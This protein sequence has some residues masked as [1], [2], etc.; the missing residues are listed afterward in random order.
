MYKTKTLRVLPS[1]YDESWSLVNIMLED[2]GSAYV[3]IDGDRYKV[4]VQT[5]TVKENRPMY[6]HELTPWVPPVVA[7]E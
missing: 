2:D 1:M 4:P 7:E 6:P 3:E 5:I